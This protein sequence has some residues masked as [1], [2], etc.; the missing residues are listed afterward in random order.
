MTGEERRGEVRYT[1]FSLH[2][3]LWVLSSVQLPTP[4]RIKIAVINI[5]STFL[6]LLLSSRL[7]LLS[8]HT[9]RIVNTSRNDHLLISEDDASLA[10]LVDVSLLGQ[11]IRS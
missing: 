11:I 5:T 1:L 4:L 9:R 10:I 8:L 3:M 7:P 2:E 6:F